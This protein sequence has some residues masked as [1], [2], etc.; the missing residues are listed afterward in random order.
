MTCICLVLIV[1]YGCISACSGAVLC[2]ALQTTENNF[3]VPQILLYSH[4]VIVL[5][6]LIFEW[7]LKESQS[8]L[9]WKTMYYC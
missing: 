4:P 1:V 5:G 7:K 2:T 9:V 3:E 8:S 6:A